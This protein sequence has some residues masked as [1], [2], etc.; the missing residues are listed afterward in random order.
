[1]SRPPRAASSH[2]SACLR[3]AALTAAFLFSAYL[4]VRPA[5]ADVAVGASSGDFL[6]FEV[7]GRSAGMAG[8][9]TGVATGVTAQFWN[10][11]GLATLNQSQVG[12]MHANWLQDLSYEWLGIAKPMG[13]IGVGSLS[14]AYFH[15]PGIQGVDEFDNPTGDF[16]VY[17][18]AVTA[19][20]ARA[21]APGF[22]IGANAK[23]IRQN[24][25]TVSASA[26][27]VDFGARATIAG[28]S[29]GAVVQ[30]LGPGLSFDGASYPLPREIKFGIGRSFWKDRVQLA[31][32]YNMP[33]H[34]F[35]DLRVGTEVRAHPNVSLRVGYR[36]EFGTPEDPANGLSYGLGIHFH[37]LELDYAMTPSDAFD[38]VHRLS[39]GYSFGAGS[40]EKKPEKP[41]PEI[42]PP[43][44]PAQPGPKVIAAAPAKPSPS[45]SVATQQGTGTSAAP[46]PTAPKSDVIAQAAPRAVAAAPVTPAAA[47]AVSA[48]APAAPAKQAKPK[49]QDL[50]YSV[51]L[52]GYWTKE[53]AQ[54]E[55]KALELLGFRVKEAQI[56][57]ASGTSYQVRLARMRSRSNADN[58][59]AS[60]S[61]M[62]FRASVE[63]ASAP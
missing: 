14:V 17:D 29:L 8:A 63:V 53:S 26:P 55:L 12:A 62:S 20:I 5:F 50:E 2:A 60:L 38:D 54:A 15:T 3:I 9:H 41:K 49:K 58:M 21:L 28:A 31:A 56:E 46:A 34:Y 37:Q 59:A 43:P 11:A 39:F 52:P 30:N 27:A 7:G 40:E 22:S 36:H 1:M 6:S 42:E 47:P 44:P 57:K 23:M 32:D 16:R 48:E 4:S 18:I 13:G 45:A 33:S 25:G 10:P 61:R 35:D 19:G 51:I 24:L